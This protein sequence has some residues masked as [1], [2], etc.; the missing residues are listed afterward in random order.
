M[1][2]G[3]KGS[4]LSFTGTPTAAGT[5]AGSVTLRDALG[6]IV[7]RTFSITINPTA[8]VGNLTATQWTVGKGNFTG[9][10]TI[11]A[12]TAPFS[13]T[14]ASGL[15]A[16][17]T[18][19]VTGNTIHFA[20]TPT[21]AGTF[22]GT[23]ILHDAAGASIS[24]TFTITINPPVQITTTALPSSMM[25]ALYSADLKVTGGTGALPSR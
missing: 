6:T 5:F 1:L 8:S 17:M 21:T 10:M 16:G 18:A 11:S 7:T 3:L 20:G 23:I 24:K 13:I 22:A 14:S 2:L 19:S 15:P 9:V 4:T 25:A 12:G